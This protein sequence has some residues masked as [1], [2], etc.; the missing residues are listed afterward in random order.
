MSFKLFLINVSTNIASGFI[1][2]AICSFFEL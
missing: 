1:V 2:Y